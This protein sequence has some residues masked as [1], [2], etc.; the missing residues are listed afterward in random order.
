M[1]QGVGSR[2]RP[3]AALGARISVPKNGRGA[4]GRTN[5][6]TGSRESV[7]AYVLA[8]AG[9]RRRHPDRMIAHRLRVADELSSVCLGSW[10]GGIHPEG[11]E[12]I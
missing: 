3:G 7:F 10:V 4:R 8:R 1:P 9:A 12:L 2:L 11:F 6:Q 5:T